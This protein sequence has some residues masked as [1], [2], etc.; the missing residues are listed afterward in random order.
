MNPSLNYHRQ[1]TRNYF[2]QTSFSD[3]RCKAFTQKM[4]RSLL[5]SSILN[6]IEMFVSFSSIDDVTYIGDDLELS[7]QVQSSSGSGQYR[8]TWQKENGYMGS[9]IRSSGRRSILK[10]NSILNQNFLTLTYNLFLQI[11]ISTCNKNITLKL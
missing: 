7:C 11:Y 3:F 8:I 9:N 6:V 2:Y 4:F 10:I 1:G 5:I